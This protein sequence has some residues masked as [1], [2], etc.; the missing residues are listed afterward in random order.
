MDMLQQQH[1]TQTQ[2]QLQQDSAQAAAGPTPVPTPF[3]VVVEGYPPSTSFA[4]VEEA[5]FVLTDAVPHGQRIRRL[6]FFLTQ[7]PAPIP[8]GMVASVYVSMYPHAEWRF[9][10]SVSNAEPSKV[11][12]VHWPEKDVAD[13]PAEAPCQIGVT[14]EAG[15]A[16]AAGGVEAQV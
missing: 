3:G 6:T 11:L 7:V 10:G 15:V 14:I 1:M 2:T 5:R 8:E 4:Q 12:N 13:L 9:L 16:A